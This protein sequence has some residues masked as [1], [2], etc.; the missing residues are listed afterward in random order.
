[1]VCDFLQ[2]IELLH[3]AGTQIDLS[4]LSHPP[5]GRVLASFEPYWLGGATGRGAEPS[6]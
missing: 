4:P 5:I 2:K 3:A 6:M 1:M